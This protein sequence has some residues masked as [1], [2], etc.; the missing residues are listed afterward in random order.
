MKAAARNLELKQRLLRAI[1]NE[2]AIIEW[3][4]EDKVKREERKEKM[5]V[6]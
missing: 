5:R 2:K 3:A 4:F 1:P 6:R